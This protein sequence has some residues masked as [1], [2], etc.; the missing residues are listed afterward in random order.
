MS[1]LKQNSYRLAYDYEIPNY[2]FFI[3]DSSFF[4]KTQAPVIVLRKYDWKI[5]FIQD[6]DAGLLT[7]IFKLLANKENY[8]NP[9]IIAETD[10]AINSFIYDNGFG[11][12]WQDIDETNYS[13]ISE[14]K[15]LIYKEI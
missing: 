9:E 2:L 10:R 13:Y 14:H 4:E 8:Q 11:I 15:Q 1:V 3:D 6:A 5:A 7:A 12:V